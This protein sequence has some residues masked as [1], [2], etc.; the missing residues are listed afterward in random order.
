MADSILLC[1]VSKG[2]KPYFF[3][4]CYSWVLGKPKVPGPITNWV[5]SSIHHLQTVNVQLQI[6]NIFW[7]GYDWVPIRQPVWQSVVYVKTGRVKNQNM[8]CTV[9]DRIKELVIKISV[10]FQGVK[11]L[12][13]ILQPT[14]TLKNGKVVRQQC[15][16][17]QWDL[18]AQY[19]HVE[20]FAENIKATLIK[21]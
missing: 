11:P 7:I 21:S 9:V 1:G 3:N 8:K 13:K 18:G 19:L 14:N 15:L 4:H 10:E 2:M 20:V 12:C 17:R 6:I 16:S 5:S